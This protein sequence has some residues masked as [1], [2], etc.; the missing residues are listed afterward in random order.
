MYQI[1]I[2]GALVYDPRLPEY[3]I[4]EG[5]LKQQINK[6]GS[7]YVTFPRKHPQKDLGKRLKSTITVH[8]D[9]ET[10]YRGRILNEENGFYGTRRLVCEGQLAFFNDS[11]VRPYEYTGSVEGYVDFLISQHNGQVASDRRFTL[12]N[13]TVVDSNDYIVRASS[14]YPKTWSEIEEK[15][16]KNLGGYII[17]RIVGDTVYIDYLSDVTEKNQQDVLFGTNLIDLS[18]II[19]GQ[20]VATVLIPL[21]VKDED[22]NRLTIKS[23]ND[24]NDYIESE[25]AIQRFGRITKTVF[26]DDV[27]IAQNLLNKGI[28][29]L[30][31]SIL[32]AETINA[33]AADLSAAGYEIQSFRFAKYEKVIS[34]PHGLSTYMLV[35]K[36]ETDLLRP[37]NGK[38]TLG[39]TKQ[40]YTSAQLEMKETQ[41][42][43]ALNL[44]DLAQNT[45]KTAE[46][47]K[48]T[49]ASA[50]TLLVALDNEA[51]VVPTD[52]DGSNGDYSGCSSG[53]L[54][55]YGSTD[56][57]ADAE[58]SVSASSGITGSWDEAEMRYIVTDMTTATGTVTFTVTYKDLTASKV[59]SIS[60][61]PAGEKGETGPQGQ[62][63]E[64][65][66]QGIQGEQGQTGSTGAAGR[67]YFITASTLVIRKGA[68]DVLTPENVTF[69]G[70]YRNGT[71]ATRTIYSGRFIIEES[72]DGSTWTT[73][74]TSGANE[75]AVTYTPGSSDVTMI[76]CTMYAAGGTANALDQQS[77]TV[78]TD[79]ENIE[80]ELDEIRAEI[81]NSSTN[82]VKSANE[83]IL[84]AVKEYVKTTDFETL[85]STIETQFKQ[86]SSSFEFNFNQLQESL[87]NLQNSTSTQFAELSKWVRIEDGVIKLGESG[88]E[89]EL[90]IDNDI[91][92]FVDNGYTASYWKDRRFYCVDG[93]FTHSLR[94]GNFAFLPRV[95]GNLTFKK[96]KNNG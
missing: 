50:N 81:V 59:M 36:M 40:S 77:V 83:I 73:N 51:H 67:V 18:Q 95:N 48:Q 8:R 55:L 17:P 62:Q 9:N 74:Y 28:K 16:I 54:V 60:K 22:G 12:G 53:V 43:D 14:Q 86:T 42:K 44:F 11:T 24:G 63:G 31:E 64:K 45:Q 69:S 92:Y 37:E 56:V 25:E 38:L 47:A 13:V 15:L 4:E 68:D 80:P 66:E 79:V 57:T 23:V 21:G 61:A 1:K 33:T 71:T 89:I 29:D 2:D 84:E 27:T 85:R 49:A 91:V 30:Q 76:R 75:N 65:G 52:S 26:H 94:L 72:E 78:V 39:K 32:S 58:I 7:F 46:E 6:A 90:R 3:R 87:S 70:Y 5:L 35:S 88:N 34:S 20:D 93:E 82:A 19:K 96:V 10:I 41:K